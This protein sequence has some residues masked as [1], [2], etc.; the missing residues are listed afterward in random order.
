MNV[1]FFLGANSGN[2]FYSLYNNFANSEG[3]FLYLIKG[4]PGSG[5]SCF[6]R[7]IAAKA[8]KLGLDV[9]YILCS[10]DPESLDGIYIPAL[11]T[12]F[13]DATAP[14]IIEPRLFGFDSCYVDLGEFCSR[15]ES[16]HIAEYTAIYKAM[17]ETAYAFLSA[18]ASIEKVQIPGLISKKEIIM[19][20]KRAKSALRRELGEL[21]CTLKTGK[22]QKRFIRGISCM[23][24]LCLNDSLNILCK[25]IYLIDDRCGLSKI[26]L[27]EIGESAAARGESIILCPNPLCP[28]ELDAV[29]LPEYSLGFVRASVA[30]VKKPWRHVRLD[31]LIPSDRLRAYKS[32]LKAQE[33]L[34]NQLKE[35]AVFYLSKAKENHDLLEAEYKPLVNFDALNKFTEQFIDE[36]FN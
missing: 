24:E 33:K 34:C 26:Y 6:M 29:L 31:A 17:Y 14:H 11:K 15:T 20:Q 28:D 8:E 21:R 25:Q 35:N 16:K 12:G 9:E 13:A 32:E 23:G 1:K 2:G 19:T 36:L 18:A 4:G 7:K 3:D 30:P 10:G 5:K 27:N 22:I